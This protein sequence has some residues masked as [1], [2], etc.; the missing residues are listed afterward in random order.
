MER[1]DNGWIRIYDMFGD[2]GIVYVTVWF[3][4]RDEH[5]DIALADLPACAA[6]MSALQDRAIAEGYW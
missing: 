3:S 2:D 1:Q 4:E 6:Q 5:A